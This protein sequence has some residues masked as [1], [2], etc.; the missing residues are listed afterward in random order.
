MA[1]VRVF[2]EDG[3]T[4]LAESQIVA[5]APFNLRVIRALPGVTVSSWIQV[6]NQNGESLPLEDSLLQ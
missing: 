6:P 5:S 3:T 4:L 1:I 2:D